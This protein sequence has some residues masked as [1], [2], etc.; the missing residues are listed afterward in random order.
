MKRLGFAAG[1]LVTVLLVLQSGDVLAETIDAS[2]DVW[3]REMPG[4]TGTTYES[5]DLSVWARNMGD[6]AYRRFTALEFDISGVADP[7]TGAY[8]QLY[9][10]DSI[11][12]DGAFDQ[13]AFLLSPHGIGSITWDTWTTYA[14]VSLQSLG[15]YNLAAGLPRQAWYD[16]SAASE[17]D[18]ANLEALRTSSEKKITMLLADGDLGL[19]ERD[20]GDASHGFAPRLVLTTTPVPEPATAALLATGLIGLLAYAWRKRK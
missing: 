10:R 16:S 19:G 8:L 12:S 14:R 4:F 6:G 2:T 20:W 3:I 11:H 17:S 7:I 5:D 18:V 1:C 13:Q 9:A 15:A